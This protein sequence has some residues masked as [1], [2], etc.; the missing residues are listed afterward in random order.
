MKT[1]ILFGLSL[2]VIC[3]VSLFAG[4][5]FTSYF[6]TEE[7]H[8][9][10][11]VDRM[12]NEAVLK[13]LES[14]DILSAKRYITELLNVNDEYLKKALKDGTTLSDSTKERIQ[15]ELANQQ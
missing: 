2:V 13:Y 10:V 8:T 4:F 9:S 12:H 7:V 15:K 5:K 6:Y 11:L 1:K 3:L 14:G